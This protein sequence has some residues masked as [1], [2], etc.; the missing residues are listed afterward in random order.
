[1]ISRKR[2]NK[3][4]GPEEREKYRRNGKERQVQKDRNKWTGN[5]H[6]EHEDREEECRKQED[7]EQEQVKNHFTR[8]I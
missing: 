5:S 1:M 2:G 3:K 6:R 4:T 7:R 8:I